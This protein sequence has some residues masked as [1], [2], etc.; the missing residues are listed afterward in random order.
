[1]RLLVALL[2]LQTAACGVMG[3]TY[4]PAP[5]LPDGQRIPYRNPRHASVLVSVSGLDVTV[6]VP[7]DVLAWWF[8]VGVPIAPFPSDEWDRPSNVKLTVRLNAHRDGF[9]F[10]PE[11]VR[12][13]IPGKDPV[14]P[15]ERAEQGGVAVG[16][17]QTFD[18]EFP[19][20][21]PLE[22]TVELQLGGIERDGKPVQVPLLFLE[23]AYPLE[24]AL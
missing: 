17:N 14:A 7:R 8:V 10:V 11:R 13:R 2:L 21:S 9:T 23:P 18:L 15:L 5:V 20:A 22:Q 1:M 24:L 12:L 3:K 16:R 6:T 4:R 19:I